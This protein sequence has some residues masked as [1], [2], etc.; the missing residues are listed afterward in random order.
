M[1]GTRRQKA[2]KAECPECSKIGVIQE[3]G[4]L[5]EI[6]AQIWNHEISPS[7]AAELI[8]KHSPNSW[9]GAQGNSIHIQT[10]GFVGSR[11]ITRKP[12]LY[13][14]RSTNKEINNLFIDRSYAISL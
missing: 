12:D 5:G 2:S 11:A 14:I 13:I 9:H 1:S 6:L 8:L 4:G 7:Q 10:D 3:H